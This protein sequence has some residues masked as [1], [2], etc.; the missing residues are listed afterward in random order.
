[1]TAP[2][3]PRYRVSAPAPAPVAPHNL[4]TAATVLED[5][6]PHA[7]TGVQ[8]E[9]VCNTNVDPYPA[10]CEPDATTNLSRTKVP[11]DTAETVVGTPF[12]VYAADSCVLGRDEDTARAQLRQRF[13]LG[14]AE[15]VEHIVETG[16]AANWPNLHRDPTILT[17]VSTVTVDTL[18]KAV[19]ML[20][21]WLADRFGT[22][23]VIHAPR[24]Y[25]ETAFAHM[26]VDKQGPRALTRMGSAWVFGTGYTGGA[27]DG[28][29]DDGMLWLYATPPVT[30]RRTGVIEPATWESGAF[31]RETNSGMLI[32]ER[33]Y[34]VDWP[35]AA[36]AIKTTL[37]RL[38]YT[39]APQPP[40][41]AAAAN[42]T[43]T[44]TEG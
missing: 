11:Q 9:A 16:V 35:C 19:G 41:A 33:I 27:P 43:S 3:V 21:Q 12:G 37:P 20:E 28:E 13:L 39:T 42:T 29:T 30:V 1:M 7:F 25:A 14:E 5:V 44:I 31:N 18:A 32:A 36:A 40:A 23:G 17:P 38:D 26:Q 2:V 8:Y 4:F 34:V 15:T 6:D 10:A 24:S 22:L